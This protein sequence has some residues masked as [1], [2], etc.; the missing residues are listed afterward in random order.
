MLAAKVPVAGGLG[1]DF[2]EQFKIIE[3]EICRCP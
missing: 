3:R 2:I 1:L